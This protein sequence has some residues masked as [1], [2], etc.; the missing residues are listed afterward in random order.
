MLKENTHDTAFLA[1][2]VKLH[3]YVF[4]GK[5]KRNRCYAYVIADRVTVPYSGK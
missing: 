1:L 3:V 5:V 4:E 2:I